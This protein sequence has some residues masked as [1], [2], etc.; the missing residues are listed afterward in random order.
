M[1]VPDSLTHQYRNLAARLLVL[2]LAASAV[3][4]SP[5]KPLLAYRANTTFYGI[6]DSTS[7]HVYDSS[8]I[9][10]LAPYKIGVDTL[11]RTV[12]CNASGPLTKAQPESSLG[13]L[14]ADATLV[15]AKKIDRRVDFAVGNYG[16]IRISYIAPGPITRGKV[17]EL[18]PFDNTL[19]I[20]DIPGTVLKEFC[21]YMAQRRGWPVAGITYEIVGTEARNIRF[22]ARNNDTLRPALYYRMAVSDYIAK[23]GD[24]ADMLNELH[25]NPTTLFIRDAIIDYLAAL[26]AEGKDLNPTLDNRVRYA[27]QD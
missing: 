7:Q 18:M 19:M 6:G 12:V 27:S 4:C 25:K 5:R 2:L 20:V 23:G 3:A 16:G 21:D 13:N 9:A 15:A 22:P 14:V 1:S 8:L 17:Y 10:M 11:M 24:N 26:H